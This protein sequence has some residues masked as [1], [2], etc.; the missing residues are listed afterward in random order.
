[1][2]IHAKYS[3]RSASIAKVFNLSL[4]VAA[5]EAMGAEGLVACEDGEVFDLLP[6]RAAVVRAF[7]TNQRPIAQQQKMRIRIEEIAALAASETV[8][9]PPVS[10][11]KQSA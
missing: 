11:F 7:A 2:T 5:S 6:T 3:L 8:D 1:M 4:T 9:V 10:S